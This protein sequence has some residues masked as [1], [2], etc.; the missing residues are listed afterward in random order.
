MFYSGMHLYAF[1]KARSALSFGIVTSIF[2]I[3]FMVTMIF[4]PVLVRLSEKQGLEI[5]ARLMS[6]IGYTWMG[7]LFLFTSVSLLFDLYHL[8]IYLGSLIVK[9]DLIASTPSSRFSFFI[10]L[11]LSIIIATYGYFEAKNIRTERITVK[12]SKIPKEVGSLK[13]VQISDV[14]I[15]LI[16]REERL[17]R[18]LEKVDA[19]HPDLLVSTGDL[20]DGQINSLAG[21]S[22]LFKTIMPRYGKFAITG[23][24]EFYAG[25]DQS[26][27]FTEQS[28]FVVLRGERLT[29]AGLINIAGV[30]DPTGERYGL[31]KDVGEKELL[32]GL[33]S[34]TFTLLLKHRP[35]L[36]KNTNS[37]FDLQ[38][39][40]HTHKGQIFPFSLITRLYYPA[41]SGYLR[42]LDN[43]YLYVSRGAGTWGPPIRFLSPP[44]VTVIE[45]FHE[46][47]K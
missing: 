33:S 30:D 16:I 28:G 36:D 42:L 45:L 19:E 44:E 10:P 8:L 32:S 6:Y 4:A 9:K 39:S 46:D 15:G 14:H 47:E 1:L 38:L 11:I 21:L 3:L 12:T 18:I 43:S 23:N 25:L 40:G 13:I 41:D 24:H 5:F 27:E 20:V 2:L 34:E 37:L 31:F 7:L 35:L 29:V 17:K 22:E 26:L